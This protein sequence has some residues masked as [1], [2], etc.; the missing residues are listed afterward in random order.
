MNGRDL[1]REYADACRKLGLK[2]GFYYSPP[3]WHFNS[4][5]M[6]FMN[7]S[8]TE[9]YPDRKHKDIDHKDIEGDLPVMPQAHYDRYVDYMN[10][11]VRELLTNYGRVDLLWFDG[12]MKDLTNVITIEEI[13]ALQP[14][15]VVNDRLWGFGIGDYSSEYECRLPKE[16]PEGPWETCQIWH[17]GGG[18]SYVK[19]ADKYRD[20]ATTLH[21]YEVCKEWGG[22]LLL[23]IA[24]DKDGVVPDAYYKAVRE[25]GDA[26]KNMR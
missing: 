21:Q 16:K 5:Y 18:W 11:Q 15:I 14:Q 2:V 3:D 25:F 4:D 24:P 6:S 17:V 22:N 12:S 19:N 1:V 8:R 7:G 20:L 9:A 23:N 10:T 13:R 26:I